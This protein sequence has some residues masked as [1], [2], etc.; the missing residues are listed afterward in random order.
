MILASVV[1]GLLVAY[2]FGVRPGVA[3]AVVAFGL[4]LLPVVLP[5]LAWLPYVVIGSG[6][7]AVCVI[8]PRRADP[9]RAAKIT[10]GARRALNLVKARL[11]W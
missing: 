11:R 1:V 3:A 8:G 7:A 10:R 5:A 9:T 6:V 2:Y 4:W